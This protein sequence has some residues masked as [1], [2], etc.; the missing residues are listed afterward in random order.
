MAKTLREVL[1]QSGLT[2]EQ[3][4]ALDAQALAKADTFVSGIEQS[5]LQKEKDALAK[6]QAA[7]AAAAKAEADKL[8]AEAAQAAA[9]AAQ[10]KAELDNRSVQEFWNN[11]YN[12]GVAAWEAE[13]AKLAK[14]AADA[15]AKAAFY[16]AQRGSYLDV[17]GIKPEDAPEF[18]P[19]AADPAKPVVTPGT[20]TFTDPNV[21]VAKVGDGFNVITDISWKYSQLYPGQALPIAPSELI[22]Q[23]DALKLSPM[24]Y[25]SRTFKFAEKEAERVAAARKAELDAAT[26]AAIAARDAE[27]KTE[28]DKQKAE[29]E[30]DLRK[31]AEQFSSNPLVNT[32]PG[33]AKFADL[34]RAQAAGER[35]D[36]LTMTPEQRREATRTNIHKVIEERE[37]Q[38]V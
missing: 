37:A 38:V 17:L 22:K 2:Q 5:A 27:H 3:I 21:L 31:K 13:K 32:P 35:K 7:I 30:A 1:L 15:L 28:M 10:E 12:P 23:A 25:A 26:T 9:K 29:Y 14:V 20:P 19:V 36:P 16:E 11:T 8:A 6:E 33:S 4:D 34:R 18:K 24:E